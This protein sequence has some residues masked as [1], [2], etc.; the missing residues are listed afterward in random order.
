MGYTRLQL[1]Q[2][3]VATNAL[4]LFEALDAHRAQARQVT[5]SMHWKHIAGRDYLYR[6]YSHGRNHSLGPRSPE[7]EALKAAFDEKKAAHKAR[8][9]SL[10]AQL[11]LHAAYIRANRLH[12]FPLP[13]ARV[14][15][16][17]QRQLVP[18]RI[19]G[20]N[21]LYAY[22]ARA[23]VLIEPEHLATEDVDVLMDVRQ[24]VRIATQVKPEGLLALLQ[25][26]DKTFQRIADSTFTFCA[27][28]SSGYR[29]DF[30][31]QGLASP[32]AVNDFERLLETDD[33]TPVTITS[34]K[35]LVASP[36]FS[37]V[38]FDERGMP[39]K[40]ETVDP[41]AFVLHKWYV[42]QQPDRNPL[43]KHRDAAQARLV[44]SL[45]HHELQE[46]ATSRAVARVFPSPV[47]HS[48]E[49]G[50]DEFDV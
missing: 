45:L 49:E 16:A 48:A 37:A 46:L 43:K 1:E 38:V 50:L 41:R 28:N 26:T 31:T 14:I 5:G 36:R 24:G 33:L 40:V 7:T 42:S 17:L 2:A 13:A 8:E 4:Q 12:R 32:L 27:V 29:V 44:S 3:R 19:I 18:F 6:G 10:K 47:R 22:E 25:R 30:I 20:T 35:W 15:R 34:L 39:L 23:G 21:A 9:A 11:Q